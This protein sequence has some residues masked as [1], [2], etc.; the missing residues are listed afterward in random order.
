MFKCFL[1]SV[2]ISIFFDRILRSKSFCSRF[3]LCVPQAPEFDSQGN[4]LPGGTQSAPL[5]EP[6][7]QQRR[8]RQTSQD[9]V[10]YRMV[11][12]YVPRDTSTTVRAPQPN[13]E[14]TPVNRL[15]SPRAGNPAMAST[16]PP[17]LPTPIPDRTSAQ[18]ARNIRC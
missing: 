4:I 3:S 9:K 1:V 17:P 18:T 5:T 8:N 10:D 13:M 2:W 7:Q 14:R 6:Q 15:E 12:P 16:P 11:R